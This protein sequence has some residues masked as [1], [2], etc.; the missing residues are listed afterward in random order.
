MKLICVVQLALA[1]SALG[2]NFPRQTQFNQTQLNLTQSDQGTGPY[3][4]SYTLD[5]TLRNHT[6]FAPISPPPGLKLPV[7]LWGQTACTR[8]STVFG[9][10]LLEVASHGFMIIAD[11]IPDGPEM[12]E[13]I[14][15]TLWPSPQG[16]VEAA[17]WIVKNA[18]T[19][20]YTNVDATRLAAAGHSCGA[21]QSYFAQDQSKEIKYIGIFDSGVRNDTIATRPLLDIVARIKNPIFYFFGGPEDV[22]APNGERDYTN[23][24]ASTPK[25]KGILPSVGH[26]G[27]FWEPHAG[28]YAVAATRWLEWVLRG[29]QTSAKYFTTTAN[30]TGTAQGGGFLV[31]HAKLSQ[32]KVKPI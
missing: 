23:I 10:F 24:P 22:A 29:N 30:K 1:G 4:A 12:P 18:G 25:W 26:G 27:T 16:L 7:L 15:Y 2:A 31:E 6:I 14:A 21:I 32:I 19:G 13:A 28:E 20:K 8:N 11:G 5:D 3:P 17:A 9:T